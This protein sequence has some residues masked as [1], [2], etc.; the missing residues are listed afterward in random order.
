[1]TPNGGAGGRSA[2]L[3]NRYL[4]AKTSPRPLSPKAA[5]QRHTQEASTHGA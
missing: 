5:R 4:D 2:R 3:T 1:M